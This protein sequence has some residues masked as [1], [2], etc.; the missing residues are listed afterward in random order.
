MLLRS[1][2][3]GAESGQPGDGLIP[4]RVSTRLRAYRLA[5]SHGGRGPRECRS[6]N[7]FVVM[8]S[9]LP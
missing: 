9:R 3:C 6:T 5:E 4:T 1:V 7:A 2:E 8:C